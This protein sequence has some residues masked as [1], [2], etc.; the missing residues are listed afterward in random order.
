MDNGSKL[1]RQSLC[2]ECGGL[3]RTLALE[4]VDGKSLISFDKEVKK[5]DLAVETITLDKFLDED[6]DFCDC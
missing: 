1:V 4:I 6:K 2:K 5:Y 3:V